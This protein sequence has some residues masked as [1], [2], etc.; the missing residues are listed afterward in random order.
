MLPGAG[1]G[2]RGGPHFGCFGPSRPE[3]PEGKPELCTGPPVLGGS[4]GPG[5]AEPPL[6][7]PS[8]SPNGVPSTA[9]PGTPPPWG[10]LW[11]PGDPRPRRP[12]PPGRGPCN[13]A[14]VQGGSCAPGRAGPSRAAGERRVPHREPR[15][16]TAPGPLTQRR[17]R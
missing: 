2:V 17:G 3:A 9:A 11:D 16:G 4:Q 14:C 10:C 15:T 7:T 6:G 1:R 5:T 8:P 12:L 13:A